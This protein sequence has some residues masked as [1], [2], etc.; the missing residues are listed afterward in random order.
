MNKTTLVLKILRKFLLI[1]QLLPHS[2]LKN[3]IVAL[4]WKIINK[5][6]NVNPFVIRDG[7]LQLVFQ[8]FCQLSAFDWV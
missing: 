4:I 6:S 3:A 1:L 5:G 2:L 8:Q 7:T